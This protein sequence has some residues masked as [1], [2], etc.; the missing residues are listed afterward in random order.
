MA[1]GM[2]PGNEDAAGEGGNIRRDCARRRGGDTGKRGQCKDRG[3]VPGEGDAVTEAALCPG[4]CR[5]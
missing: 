3:T 5:D 4:W 2:M 1:H